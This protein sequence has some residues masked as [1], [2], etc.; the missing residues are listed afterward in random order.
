MIRTHRWERIGLATVLLALSAC[1][2]SFRQPEVRLA[3][4]RL[5]TIGLTGGTVF[6]RV[7]ITNP[8]RFALAA[9]GLEYDLELGDPDRD[10]AW[11]RLADGVFDGDLR[12]E[13]SDSTLVEVPL[14]FRFEG[15]GTALRSGW[16]VARWSIA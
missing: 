6:A 5:G 9:E 2:L 4:L 10:D 8:N 11:I 14:D 7:V 13:G 16:R 12:V 15:L 3:G 1:F